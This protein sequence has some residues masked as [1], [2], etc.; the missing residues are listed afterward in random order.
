[1]NTGDCAMADFRWADLH[2]T[3]GATCR[4]WRTPL[5]AKGVSLEAP[6]VGA[7]RAIVTADDLFLWREATITH[8]MFTNLAD[9]DGLRLRLTPGAISV[10]QEAVAFPACFSFVYKDVDAAGEQDVEIRRSAVEHWLRSNVRLFRI[11]PKPFV[12][13][14]YM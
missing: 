2:L 11:D 7:A 3:D 10:H 14:W 13:D 8:A 12:I 5:N 9:I 1:M 6:L 4:I